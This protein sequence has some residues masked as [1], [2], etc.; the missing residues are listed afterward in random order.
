[1]PPGRRD[2]L[3]VRAVARATR[4]DVWVFRR[5]DR[6]T[7]PLADVGFTTT[8]GLP[9]VVPEVQ[10]LFKAKQ[11]RPQ[12][13]TD[14]ANVLPELADD[15]RAW[16]AEAIELVHPGHPWVARISGGTRPSS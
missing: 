13:E 11:A 6:I 14:L 3:V 4:G 16:L 15:R 2:G 10:L 7:L 1:M 12:D 9:V 5:D 8:D